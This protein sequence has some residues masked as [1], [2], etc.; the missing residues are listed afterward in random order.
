MAQSSI[1]TMPV[2]KWA[3]LLAASLLL[4]TLVYSLLQTA[5]FSVNH[6]W[7]RWLVGVLASAA[8]IELYALFVKWFEKR[9]AQDIPLNRLT[10]DT[11]KGLAVGFCFFVLV[12][13]AMMLFGLY[14]IDGIGTDK[15]LHIISAF[16]LFL[17]VGTG[18]E[19]LFRGVLFRWIDEKWGFPA[20]LIVSSVLFGL[21]HIFEPD[22][23]LWSSLAI[24]VEAGL[25]LGAAYK[26]SGTLWLPIGIHW[27]WN[28]TQGNIF[29]FEVSGSD[30]G[31]ALMKATV[32]GPEWLTGGSFGAEA[33]VITVFLGL[34][35]SVW[36]IL[37]IIWRKGLLEKQSVDSCFS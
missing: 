27:A 29:G 11:A 9:N 8:M 16:F 6:Q 22:A 35:L 17:L 32:S 3:L 4:A 2:W 26:Y 5:F 12:V 14:R 20:A 23:T 28:F 7:V 10:S 1:K 30:A 31:V 36:F 18:E 19:I 25:L 15:P 13:L 24:A 33:S 34:A 21:M 37:K